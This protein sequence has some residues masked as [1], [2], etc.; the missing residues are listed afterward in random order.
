MI[1]LMFTLFLLYYYNTFYKKNAIV[2][3]QNS[4]FY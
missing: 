3:Y 4:V 1:F 2:L